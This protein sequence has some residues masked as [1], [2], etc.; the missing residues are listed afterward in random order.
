MADQ[1]VAF[2]IGHVRGKT[3]GESLLEEIELAAARR[4]VHASRESQELG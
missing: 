4:I 3:G 2:V 1:A